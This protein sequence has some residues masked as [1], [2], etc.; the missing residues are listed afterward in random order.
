MIPVPHE[1]RF[2]VDVPGAPIQRGAAFQLHFA[3][4]A[5]DVTVRNGQVRRLHVD[6]RRVIR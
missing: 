2:G 6:Q 4:P 1:Q 3:L 5:F